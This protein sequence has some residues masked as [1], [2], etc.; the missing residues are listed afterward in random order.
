MGASNSWGI[1]GYSRLIVFLKCSDN[2]RG[3]TVKRNFIEAIHEY[4]IPSRIRTD[5]GGEN[6]QVAEND[7]RVERN[8]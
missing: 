1:D 7:V 2:N 3:E 6:M 5:Q 4:G 8:W